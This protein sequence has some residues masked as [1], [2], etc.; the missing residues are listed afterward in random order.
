MKKI[1]YFGVG[2]FS[3]SC[4]SYHIQNKK[5]KELNTEVKNLIQDLLVDD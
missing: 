4:V 2:F 1:L 5:I 3:G